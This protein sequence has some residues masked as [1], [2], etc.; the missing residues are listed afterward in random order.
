MW[1]ENGEEWTDLNVNH[2]NLY[3]G[4]LEFNLEPKA[5]LTDILDFTP[6][7]YGAMVVSKRLMEILKKYNLGNIQYRQ[8]QINSFEGVRQDFEYYLVQTPKF[9]LNNIDWNITFFY[10]VLQSMEKNFK[11]FTYYRVKDSQEYLE[12]SILPE[13]AMVSFKDD[14]NLDYIF[15]SLGEFISDELYIDLRK[16]KLTN[17]VFKDFKTCFT[18]VKHISSFKR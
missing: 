7:I 6:F 14:N 15:S 11:D 2:I 16:H 17:I 3:E 12:L 9:D 8:V 13:V 18:D 5:K 4:I 10:S 1:L